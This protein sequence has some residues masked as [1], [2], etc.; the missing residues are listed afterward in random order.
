MEDLAGLSGKDLADY[1]TWML[2]RTLEVMGHEGTWV[3]VV[4]LEGVCVSVCVCACVC[5]RV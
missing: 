1:Y 2:E 4:D 5:V 3:I